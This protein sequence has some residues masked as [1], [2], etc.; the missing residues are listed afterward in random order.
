MVQVLP[1]ATASELQQLVQGLLLLDLQLPSPTLYQLCEV[2]QPHLA[3][4]T[5]A[6]TCCLLHLLAAAGEYPPDPKWLSQALA[7]LEPQLGSLEALESL[8]LLQSLKA[9]NARPTQ[10]FMAA[11]QQQLMHLAPRFDAMGVAT[12]VQALAACGCMPSHSLQVVLAGHIRK[13]LARPSQGMGP[14]PLWLVLEVLVQV[15]V[16]AASA[17]LLDEVLT[18]TAQQLSLE[19]CVTGDQMLQKLLPHL[20]AAVTPG[21]AWGSGYSPPAGFCSALCSAISEVPSFLNPIL[22]LDLLLRFSSGDMAGFKP[23]RLWVQTAVGQVQRSWGVGKGSGAWEAAPAD[24]LAALVGALGRLAQQDL[25]LIGYIQIPGWPH[26]AVVRLSRTLGDLESHQLV[27]ALLG[28]G[29]L[30]VATEQAAAFASRS[31]AAAIISNS[32]S[33]GDSTSSKGTASSTAGSFSRVS[34]GIA[35]AVPHLLIAAETASSPKLSSMLGDDLALLAHAMQ[36][37]G[38][39]PSPS[40]VQDWAVAAVA[41]LPGA[42]GQSGVLCLAAVAAYQAQPDPLLVQ[43]LLQHCQQHMGELQFPELLALGRSLQLLGYKPEQGFLRS[44]AQAG[45]ARVEA[46]ERGSGLGVIEEGLPGVELR[47]AAMMELQ[48]MLLGLQVQGDM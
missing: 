2:A 14:T 17:V 15:P 11:L 34:S 10:Q 20:A 48:T 40:W 35:A 3:T 33:D 30:Y 43:Q 19:G 39:V 37:L 21:G 47:K 41:Q 18:Q 23:T 12:V 26:E 5:P 13:G 22:W 38:H 31:A 29:Q 24:K 28:V 8:M 42:S 6:V 27:M 7:G 36:Q 1:M 16:P 46:Q 44:L 9:L 25:G 32:S 4:F 45:A